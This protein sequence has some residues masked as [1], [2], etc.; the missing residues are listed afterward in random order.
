MK[1]CIVNFSDSQFQSLR[2][3]P[4]AEVEVM[5]SPTGQIIGMKLTQ[6][7]GNSDWDQAVLKAIEKTAY[8]PRDE[9]GK[10]P[11]KIPFLFR[12]RE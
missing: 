10:I 6:S 9:N 12:P 3:N 11:A 2:G 7:S 1:H 5:V 4:A 8:L